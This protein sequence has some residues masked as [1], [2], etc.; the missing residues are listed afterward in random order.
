MRRAGASGSEAELER[1]F[2][3]RYMP[4]QQFYFDTIRPT[5]HPDIIVHNDEPQHPAWEDP[6]L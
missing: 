6:T 2:H 5:D 3:E 4:S 1:R